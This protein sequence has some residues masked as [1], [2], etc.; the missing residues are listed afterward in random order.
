MSPA[1]AALFLTIGLPGK[2]LPGDLVKQNEI[3][4]VWDGA[5]DSAFL[6][7]FLELLGNG[8]MLCSFNSYSFMILLVIS[9]IACW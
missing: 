4:L 9:F 3:Q 5:Q 1:L 7:N 8:L 6:M 2:S